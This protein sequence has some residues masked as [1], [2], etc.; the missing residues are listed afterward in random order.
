M[1]QKPLSQRSGENVDLIL[2]LLVGHPELSRINVEPR[3]GTITLTF[4]VRG[5]VGAKFRTRLREHLSAYYALENVSAAAPEIKTSTMRGLTFLSIGRDTRTISGAEI[6][7]IV[8]LVRQELERAL[9][10]NPPAEEPGEDEPLARKEFV[11]SAIDAWR[12]GS[13]KK[14]LVGFRDERRVLIYFGS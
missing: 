13:Q 9:V 7:L 6:S 1:A 14:S 11:G 2:S 12:R 4:I 10:V 5:S 8:A 3:L